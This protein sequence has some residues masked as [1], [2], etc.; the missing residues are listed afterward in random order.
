MMS[1]GSD[2][3][4]HR[5]QLAEL[6]EGRAELVEELA[7][8]LAALPT[9]LPSTIAVAVP[10]A[11]DQVGQLVALEEVA[12][13]V[14]DGDLGD[15]RQPAEVPRLRRCLRHE[16]KCSTRRLEALFSASRAKIG[17]ADGAS[18][19]RAGISLWDS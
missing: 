8:V 7:E 15:L 6:D 14:P 2:V 3:G 4:A 16:P 1:G 18:H 10:A 9:A 5:E 19:G 12:E 11:R 17:E 13:A